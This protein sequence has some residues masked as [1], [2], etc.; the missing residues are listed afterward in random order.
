M[1][2][3]LDNNSFLTKD[4]DALILPLMPVLGADSSSGKSSGRKSSGNALDSYPTYFRELDEALDGAAKKALDSVEFSGKENTLFAMTTL[5]KIG[6]KRIYFVGLGNEDQFNTLNIRSSYASAARKAIADKAKTIATLYL[7]N[8][9]VS[10]LFQC[11]IEGILLGVYKFSEYKSEDEKPKGKKTSKGG[12]STSSDLKVSVHYLDKKLAPSI[13]KQLGIA[14][15][16]A[17]GSYFARDLVNRPACDLY[18]QT[19]AKEAQTLFKSK[20]FTV[21]V[22]DEKEIKRRKMLSFLSVSKG[23]PKPPR[24]IHINYKPSGRAKARVAIVGKGVTFDTGGLSLKPPRYMYDMKSDMAG[25]AAVFG[26][27]RA[28]A[29]LN[30]KVEVDAI[31]AATENIPGG[32]STR[33]GDVVRASN[34]KTIEVLNTDAE[35]RLTLADA[36]GY[37]ASLPKVDHIIDLA[38]LTGAVV[39]ALGDRIAAGMTNDD[40]LL[41]RVIEAGERAGE[42]IWPLPLPDLYKDYIKSPVADFKNI[43]PEGGIAGTIIAGMLLREFV[44]DKPWV[45]L[46]IA[47]PAF[48]NKDTKIAPR[49][50]TS[51][52]VRTL[53]EHLL[54]ISN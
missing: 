48:L 32:E 15:A 6:P 27:M 38:T 10:H 36:L 23:S 13:K 52:G 37:A 12:G 9:F 42:G 39:I 3:S 49:G 21:K 33:P 5:E 29:D 2:F 45:H 7:E 28:L 51:F 24:F 20:P 44:A 30:V 34:G 22:F 43:A 46:D 47:G 1:K 8:D 53:V 40:E 26:T 50:A 17:A 25:A 35:G 18:P 31:V 4:V 11:S 41:Q 19:L 54:R 14:E 16:V